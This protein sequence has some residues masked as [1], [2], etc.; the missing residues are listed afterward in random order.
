METFLFCS[1]PG[2][3]TYATCQIVM[4]NI[5]RARSLPF[6]PS[7]QFCQLGCK[8]AYHGVDCSSDCGLLG[9]WW[10]AW[11][12]RGLVGNGGER[13]ARLMFRGTLVEKVNV[14]SEA[15]VGLHCPTRSHVSP[16]PTLLSKHLA[17]ILLHPLLLPSAILNY[18]KECL[19]KEVSTC[20]VVITAQHT[21]GF[22]SEV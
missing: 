19:Q 12:I 18:Y 5:W 11:L 6:P 14:L 4:R 1:L 20:V 2:G 16:D 17:K 3:N 8:G 13:P 9:V 10:E 15:A 22:N 7:P 21:T